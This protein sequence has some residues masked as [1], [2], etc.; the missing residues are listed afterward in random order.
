MNSV[1]HLWPLCAFITHSM[2]TIFAVSSNQNSHNFVSFINKLILN[3]SM[4]K[5]ITAWVCINKMFNMYS[6]FC[7]LLKII[8]NRNDYFREKF[9]SRIDYR[10]FIFQA[11]KIW[12]VSKFCGH[13]VLILFHWIEH[14][15]RTRTYNI[16][17]TLLFYTR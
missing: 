14:W 13:F 7:F 9:H 11:E 6:T 4:L 12:F 10:W 8:S 1:S 16:L 2:N 5:A 3:C 15:A 17:C